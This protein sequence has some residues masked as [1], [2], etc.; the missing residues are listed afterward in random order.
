MSEQSM[1]EQRADIEARFIAAAE[2]MRP[3]LETLL[4]T[5]RQLYEV[6]REIVEKA[7]RCLAEC[8]DGAWRRALYARLLHYLPERWAAWVAAHVPRGW[9]FRWAA[10]QLRC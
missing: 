3:A 1:A 8:W 7:I 6:I 9:L 2:A 5:M 10:W 4:E